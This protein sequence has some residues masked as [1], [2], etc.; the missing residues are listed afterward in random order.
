MPS[1]PMTDDD[2]AAIERLLMHGVIGTDPANVSGATTD[3]VAESAIDLL[4][5]VLRLQKERQG[6]VAEASWDELA[7][8]MTEV[9]ADN[10]RLRAERAAMLDVIRAADALARRADR[11]D[12]LW[13]MPQIMADLEAALD[14]F[15]D[16]PG[17]A[18]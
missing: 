12:P 14:R 9:E 17:D 11:T 18:A 2:L 13:A 15:D 3:D 1:N 7:A 16:L 4:A 10:A 5:E 6:L 8:E